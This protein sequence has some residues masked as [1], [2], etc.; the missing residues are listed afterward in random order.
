MALQDV[1]ETRQKEVELKEA[2]AKALQVRVKIQQSLEVASLY[3]LLESINF[4]QDLNRISRR[5][6]MLA[7][8]SWSQ[9]DQALMLAFLSCPQPSLPKNRMTAL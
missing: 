2:E 8:E 5:E 7:F 3:T 9:R 4:E 6:T 1:L